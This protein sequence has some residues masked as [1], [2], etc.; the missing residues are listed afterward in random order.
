MKKREEEE[1]AIR[2]EIPKANPPYKLAKEKY[3]GHKT[4]Q[5]LIDT[6]T[7]HLFCTK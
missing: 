1:E 2:V 4:R 5:M 7:K 3:V 6:N